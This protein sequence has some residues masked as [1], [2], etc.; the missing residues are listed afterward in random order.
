MIGSNPHSLQSLRCLVSGESPELT[1]QL[2]T[3]AAVII[4]GHY[5]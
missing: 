1:Y 4:N 3:A 2:S 5:R